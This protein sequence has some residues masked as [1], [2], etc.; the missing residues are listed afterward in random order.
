MRISRRAV[1][2]LVAIVV[3]IA[4]L[5]HG[6]GGDAGH[7]PAS[8]GPTATA[9]ASSSSADRPDDRNSPGDASTPTD[10]DSTETPASQPDEG[11]EQETPPAGA[12]P[13]GEITQA[14]TVAARYV[15]NLL[16]FGYSDRD[17]T[18]FITRAAPYMTD[19]LARSWRTTAAQNAD[20][21][22]WGRLIA[23]QLRHVTEVD[24]TVVASWGGRAKLT[25]AIVFRSG[26]TS[27]GRPL[28]GAETRREAAVV[29]VKTPAGW[30]AGGHT[31]V[32]PPP[33]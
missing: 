24:D 1:G 5:R 30:R 20:G 32:E 21:P 9:A 15:E 33:G 31:M 27:P 29:M 23:Q 10:P 16:T 11:D 26:D 7:G 14:K 28:S 17:A 22:E 4:V 13:A 8:A 19:E 3:V 2:A 25:V 12:P 6:P 18:D